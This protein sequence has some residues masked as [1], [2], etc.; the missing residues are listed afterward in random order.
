MHSAFEIIGGVNRLA[1]WAN[2][3]PE[4]FYPLWTRALMPSTSV[5]VHG[6]NTKVEIVHSLPATPLDDHK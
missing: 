2:A 4:K 5:S 6:D 3:N 1:L